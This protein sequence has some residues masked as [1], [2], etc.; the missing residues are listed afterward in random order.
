MHLA[1][2]HILSGNQRIII[3][4]V[5]VNKLAL[6][7]YTVNALDSCQVIKLIELPAYAV[8]FYENIM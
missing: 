7:M 3:I 2:I 1:A 4:I 8:C 5:I 6:T